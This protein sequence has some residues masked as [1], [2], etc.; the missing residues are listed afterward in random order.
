MPSQPASSSLIAGWRNQPISIRILRAFL[1]VT[2]T[3]AGIQKFADPGF[4]SR[5]SASYVGRQLHG[6]AQGSPIAGLMHIASHAPVLVGLLVAL[7]E[8]AVGIATLLGIGSIAAAFIGAVI[9]VILW[10]SAT[11]HVHPYFLGSDSIYAVAWI[12]YGAYL[13][14]TQ[15]SRRVSASASRSRSRS[16]ST[17]LDRRQ[18]LRGGFVAGAALFLAG[19]GKVMAGFDSSG[20]ARASGLGTR[21]TPPS[22]RAASTAPASSPAAA[23]PAAPTA[24]AVQGTPIASLDSL[25][26]GSPI[27]F[28]DPGVGPAVLFRTATDKVEAFS[29]ICTHAGCEV[30]Y[31]SA[32]KLL[33]CPCHGAEFDPARG[34]RV[35]AGPAPTPLPKIKVAIDPSTRKVVLP[36]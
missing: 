30:G 24:A 3:Y 17:S 32:S 20:S 2:F 10:L 15:G 22:T 12:A 34:A 25:T 35:V 31:N 1:G 5:G 4:F 14:E 11:W 7:V 21:S 8:L 26:V 23:G 28:Q 9:N 6:F 16:S 33:V 13:I 19:V 29:R 36:S 18:V 27:A